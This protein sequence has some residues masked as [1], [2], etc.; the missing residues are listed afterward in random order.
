MFSK[1]KDIKQIKQGFHS[2]SWVISKG[3]D[4]GA[5]GCPGVKQNMV[6]WHSKLTGMQEKQ[7]EVKFS[8]SGHTG[9]LVVR[10]KDQVL[11][12]SNKV[13]FK[14]FY[15][16]LCVFSQINRVPSLYKIQFYAH[17]QQLKNEED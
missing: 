15:T 12:L 3:W 11:N 9:D 1:V 8:P 2:I 17:A 16:K 13:N 4:F 5:L 10:S 6:M 14:D 7:N